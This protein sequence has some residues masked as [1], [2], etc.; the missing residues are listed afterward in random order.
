MVIPYQYT[1]FLKANNLTSLYARQK[2][3]P[4]RREAK[5]ILLLGDSQ[6]DAVRTFLKECFHSDHGPMETD[7]VI[8]RTDP[9]SEDMMSILCGEYKSQV[10]YL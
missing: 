2:Y 3:Q 9:P 5:H 10:F 4:N 7:V 8:M 1:E 6:A